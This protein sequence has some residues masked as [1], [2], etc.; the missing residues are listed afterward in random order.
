MAS[1]VINLAPDKK[2]SRRAKSASPAAKSSSASTSIIDSI[3]KDR[4]AS[5]G[6]NSPGKKLIIDLAKD[7]FI[8]TD[9][10]PSATN[11]S[12]PLAIKPLVSKAIDPVIIDIDPDEFAVSNKSKAKPRKACIADEDYGDEPMNID[13]VVAEPGFAAGVSGGRKSP[14]STSNSPAGALG[15]S[16]VSR[17][18]MNKLQALDAVFLRSTPSPI[19][20]HPI[21]QFANLGS[22]TQKPRPKSTDPLDFVFNEL[23][24]P[25]KSPSP[26]IPIIPGAQTLIQAVRQSTIPAAIQSSNTSP[27]HSPLPQNQNSL[28]EIK[29]IRPAGASPLPTPAKSP[30]ISTNSAITSSSDM[31][32]TRQKLDSVNRNIHKIQQKIQERGAKEKYATM[33]KDLEKQKTKYEGR[34]KQTQTVAASPVPN[35]P[36]P[37]YQETQLGPRNPNP[38]K[39]NTKPGEPNINSP[40]T[41][42]SPGKPNKQQAIDERLATDQELARIRELFPDQ[43]ANAKRPKE[44]QSLFNVSNNLETLRDKQK[45]LEQQHKKLEEQYAHKLKQIERMRTQ[46]EE[47]TKLSALEQERRKIYEMEQKLKRLDKEQWEEQQRLRKELQTINLANLQAIS[48]NNNQDVGEF[49]SLKQQLSTGRSTAVSPVHLRQP[50]AAESNKFRLVDWFAAITSFSSNKK[51]QP[52]AFK[53]VALGHQPNDKNQPIVGYHYYNI[54]LP[55]SAWIDDQHVSTTNDLGQDDWQDYHIG[56]GQMAQTIINSIS[57]SLIS[58]NNQDRPI[59]EL[60]TELGQ[61]LG[62]HN[63]SLM[64]KGLDFVVD[65]LNSRSGNKNQ[66]L[67]NLLVKLLTQISSSISI[68]DIN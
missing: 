57:L 9:A 21:N 61:Q 39:S 36:P 51:Y 25:R 45:H 56:Q 38:A 68:L 52:E 24:P 43:Q 44:V 10:K 13:D 60:I 54:E 18:K 2:S 1:K 65:K 64:A 15:N 50:P 4:A 14:K 30:N 12:K 6:S 33:L 53:E 23:A 40:R 46:K 27:T 32:L 22:P 62:C 55:S 16:I 67:L 28:G 31:D 11:I 66:S 35:Y 8:L 26:Q 19:P 49:Y 48:R 47:M 41:S 58:K 3:L 63:T 7:N 29:V 34:L 59:I 17:E 5:T 37:S 20:E 42:P